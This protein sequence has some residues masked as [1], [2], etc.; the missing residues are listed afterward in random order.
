MFPPIIAKFLKDH[1]VLTLCTQNNQGQMWAANAFYV[2]DEKQIALYFLSTEDTQH[3][4]MMHQQSEVVGTISKQSK[5]IS[6]IQ[7]VQYKAQAMLLQEQ[8]AEAAYKK[9]YEHFRMAC[10]IKAPIWQLALNN[11]KFTDNQQGF[12]HKILWSR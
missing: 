1:H 12:G 2:F 7:G 5:N 4:K 10:T 9:Y 6:L 8:A 3:V 11:I